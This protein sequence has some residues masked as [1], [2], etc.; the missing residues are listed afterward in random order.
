VTETYTEAR[1]YAA[2]RCLSDLWLTVQAAGLQVE[3]S[4]TLICPSCT[5]A[6]SMRY[7]GPT[8]EET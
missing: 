5:A 1:Y 7:V 3:D 2:C 6:V 4:V 8:D